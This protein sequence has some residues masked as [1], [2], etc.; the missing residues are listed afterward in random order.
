MSIPARD[1]AYETSY[2]V[3]YARAPAGSWRCHGGKIYQRE[4]QD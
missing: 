4:Q 1:T 3:Y 2:F